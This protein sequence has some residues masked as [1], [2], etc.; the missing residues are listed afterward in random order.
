M[1][2][3]SIHFPLSARLPLNK[4]SRIRATAFQTLSNVYF[5]FTLRTF[6]KP[7]EPMFVI[8]FRTGELKHTSAFVHSI[9]LWVLPCLI[10]LI[11]SSHLP[12]SYPV[13]LFRL[14]ISNTRHCITPFCIIYLLFVLLFQSLLVNDFY[15]IHLFY[16]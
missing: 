11:I 6:Y 9:L 4:I 2:V 15:K 10:I 16:S 3:P 5:T 8:Y 12:F 14:K 1:P 7:I 13:A